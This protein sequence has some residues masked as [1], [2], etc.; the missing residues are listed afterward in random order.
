MQAVVGFPNGKYAAFHLHITGHCFPIDIIRK[1]GWNF[2]AITVLG[3]V[4]K[5]LTRQL[6]KLSDSQFQELLKAIHSAL[7]EA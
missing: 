3:I 6:G 1:A 5:R 2:T 7:D 4:G